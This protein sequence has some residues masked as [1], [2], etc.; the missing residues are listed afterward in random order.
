MR[1]LT[2]NSHGA[3]M[4]VPLSFFFLSLAFCCPATQFYVS[5]DGSDINNT[6]TDPAYPIRHIQTAFDL[7]KYGDTINIKGGI[8]REQLCGTPTWLANAGTGSADN[9]L[10]IQAWD[11]NNNGVIDAAEKPTIKTSQE[12]VDWTPVTDSTEWAQLTD[13][14]YQANTIFKTSWNVKPVSESQDPAVDTIHLVMESDSQAL[15]QTGWDSGKTPSDAGGIPYCPA[16]MDA[17]TFQYDSIN[18]IL[19]VWRSDGKIPGTSHPIEAVDPSVLNPNSSGPIN[20][21]G[22][23]DYI[24]IKG[25]IL[26]HSN[27]ST[28][29]IKTGVCLSQFCKMEDC[30]IQWMDYQGLSCYSTEVTNCIISHNGCMG[31]NNANVDAKIIHCTLQGNNFRSWTSTWEASAIK[32]IGRGTSAGVIISGNTILDNNC[33]GVWFDT[34]SASS[35]NYCQIANNF[36][37]G[38]KEGVILEIASYYWVYNNIIVNNQ[39][40]AIG[41][42]W[43]G[44]NIIANN[45]VV[46][47][48]V[49]ANSPV[50]FGLGAGDRGEYPG[51]RPDHTH[52][53]ANNVI[54]NNIFVTSSDQAIFS[55]QKDYNDPI[56]PRVYNNVYKNNLF[57]DNCSH[58]QYSPIQ[59]NLHDSLGFTVYTDVGLFFAAASESTGVNIANF[60]AD[61]KFYNGLTPSVSTTDPRYYELKWDSPAKDFGTDEFSMEMDF[62]NHS[63]DTYP[64]LGAF[65][66]YDADVDGI[67]DCWELYYANQLSPAGNLATFGSTSDFDHD[68]ISDAMEF[69]RGTSPVSSASKNVILYVNAING[70]DFLDG[71]AFIQSSHTKGPKKT[72]TAC[73]NSS[74]SGDVIQVGD[75]IYSEGSLDI[76]S[77]P[78]SVVI[79]G[80]VTLQ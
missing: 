4:L 15:Q 71:L 47:P 11:V 12:I 2:P 66:L 6:G 41:L 70:Q 79:E 77:R 21:S 32:I 61:P 49:P 36:I 38:N 58:P 8:Y 5:L 57:W 20:L 9:M 73:L 19:Y 44:Y 29:G 37:S 78:V 35:G 23:F 50:A 59:L 7:A 65:E 24:F 17:G 34:T 51:N 53:A 75:G 46:V 40:S 13:Q 30:D 74:L 52:D 33:P 3:A 39:G 18:R 55:I 14:P 63:R 62:S 56:D 42:S 54:A 43:A 1:F 22:G 80:S 60:L 28:S 76:S 69:F 31:V 72:I 26:R 64:D 68:G 45:T 10:T 25:L 16:K 67:A 48:D 27:N